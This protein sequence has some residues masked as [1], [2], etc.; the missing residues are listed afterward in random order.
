MCAYAFYKR[1]VYESSLTPTQYLDMTSRH[2]A[3]SC[4][5]CL[6]TNFEVNKNEIVTEKHHIC[7][8]NTIQM[9]DLFRLRSLRKMSHKWGNYTA[10]S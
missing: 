10:T 9:F 7:L 5:N 4:D 3:V 2:E 6:Q 8:G 1:A